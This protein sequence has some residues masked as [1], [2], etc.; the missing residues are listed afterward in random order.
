[1]T[2]DQENRM[3]IAR[4]AARTALMA[5]CLSIAVAASAAA[6]LQLSGSGSV[7]RA[8]SAPH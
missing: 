1:M 5:A 7:K 3:S 8:G 6:D 2:P 4:I